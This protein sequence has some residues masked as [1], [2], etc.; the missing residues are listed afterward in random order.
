MLEH[1]PLKRFAGTHKPYDESVRTVCRACTVGCGLLA[2][3]KDG[4]IVDIQGDEN[5][6]VS[7]G[8]LCA[9]GIAFHQCLDHP[10][11][12]GCLL[13]R[14]SLSEPFESENDWEKSLDSLAERLRK[15]RG[16]HGPRS[17]MIGCDPEAGLDFF[18][19]AMRFARLWG[20]ADVY[21]P[22][23]AT[24]GISTRPNPVL[25]TAPRCTDWG[26]SKCI[27]LVEADLATTHPVAFGR[28]L[29]AR[30]KGVEIIALDSR[31]TPTMSKAD[32]AHLIRPDSGNR[33]GLALMKAMLEEDPG[34]I[35]SAKALF[36]RF[37]EWK[38]SFDSLAYDGLEKMTGLDTAKVVEIAR[39][40]AVKKSVTLITGKRLS[41]RENSGV[42]RTMAQAGG[43]GSMD[44][45][46]W[47]PL[48]A[49]LPHLRPFSDI[50]ELD[51]RRNAPE[52]NKRFGGDI[53]EAAEVAE[54]P[55]HPVKALISSGNCL[56]DFMSCMRGM[57]KGA[58]L[59]IH[60]GAFPNETMNLAHLVIPAT[61]WPE[62]EALSF[63]NDR[64]IRWADRIV[65]PAGERRSGLEFW[66]GLA[67]RLA[68]VRHLE[69]KA[70]F[71]WKNEDGSA[72]TRSF[73]GWVLEQ[74]PFTSGCGIDRITANN[75][76]EP[77]HWPIDPAASAIT[78]GTIEAFAAPS[79]L[80]PLF[81]REA[82]ELFPLIYQATRTIS[83]SGDADNFRSLTRGLE[84]ADSVQIHPDTAGVL[85]IESGDQVLIH[86]PG[87]T[88]EA[89]AWITRMVPR[90][91]IWSARRLASNCAVV[92]KKDQPR[93]EASRIL[94]EFLR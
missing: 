16:R 9:R 40:L 88:I 92:C 72:D 49:G 50:D 39:R 59:N 68:D 7:R 4:K 80:K 25:P 2:F 8:R 66:T 54:D 36:D 52:E 73:Y 82:Q 94:R 24:R 34:A 43:W 85:G 1:D 27:L 11:R 56:Y 90:W 37:D 69:W 5:D 65:E 74:S 75:G 41:D 22:L 26:G 61:L 64:A 28:L 62:R 53:D 89:S 12:I 76:N 57:A 13:R 15:I 86:G 71:P 70:Y 33:F 23:Y 42:W 31:F 30:D 35:E 51:S 93:E 83:R 91:L 21:H 29:E 38:A 79:G 17:L 10:E 20:T 14:N 55:E 60:F 63:T 87:E 19:G 48:D 44:G 46:G 58:E 77:V 32:V 47:Y 45:G 78:P 3:L 84:D 18:I 67:Q 6:P 81:Q